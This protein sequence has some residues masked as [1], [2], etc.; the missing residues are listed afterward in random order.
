MMLIIGVFEPISLGCYRQSHTQIR[1]HIAS[2]SQAWPIKLDIASD[3]TLLPWLPQ[4]CSHS[5]RLPWLWGTDAWTPFIFWTTPNVMS[6][7]NKHATV[8]FH[9]VWT[10]MS[11]S[12][13]TQDT[14]QCAHVSPH[15]LAPL[16]VWCHFKFAILSFPL[17]CF[18][19]SFYSLLFPP[20]ILWPSNL[21]ATPG[22]WPSGSWTRG[23]SSN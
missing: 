21:P 4:K 8:S 23:D 7:V 2:R 5:R 6:P 20:S 1:K 11:C 22:H 10:D 13:A 15:S 18:C 12:F 9:I 19:L 17:T 16:G 3:A 14:I